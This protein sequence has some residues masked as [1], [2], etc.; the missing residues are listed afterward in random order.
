MKRMGAKELWEGIKRYRY[1]LLVLAL[2]VLLLLLPTGGSGGSSGGQEAQSAELSAD[3]WLREVQQEL[4]DTLSRI[5]GAGKLTLMLSVETGMRNELAR[6]TE[7]TLREGEQS[8]SSETVF[9]SKGSGQEEVVVIRSGYPVFR[10]AVVVC[11]GGD[12]PSVRLAV[13]QAVTALTGLSS[14]K[15]SV[16]KGNVK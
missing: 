13:T 10:G 5:E 2:G 8:L 15:I 9:I 1:A 12:S 6:D 11:E 4:A 14:D 7:Q 16:I 3:E